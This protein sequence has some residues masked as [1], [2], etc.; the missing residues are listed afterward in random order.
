MKL[1]RFYYFNLLVEAMFSATRRGLV[2]NITQNHDFN[3]LVEAMFSATILWIFKTFP[4]L[5]ISIFLLKLCSLLRGY[6]VTG[7]CES[8][9]FNL[10]VEAMFSATIETK[11]N[12][13]KSTIN[14]NLLVEAMFSAT[15]WH[16]L[17]AYT[18]G[19]ISIFLLKLC[20]L[21]HDW[22]RL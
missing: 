8:L 18:K 19:N 21:L 12:A 5:R 22:W 10:L 6:F 9:Y 7:W 2:L 14:F 15:G 11:L 20:S 3:L 16:T 4:L 17:C 1:R 13:N